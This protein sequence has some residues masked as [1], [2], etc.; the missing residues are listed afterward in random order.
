MLRITLGV[1]CL[2]LSSACAGGGGAPA[3]TTAIAPQGVVA[4]KQDCQ[5]VDS[6]FALGALV[7]RECGVERQAKA[8]GRQP[9]MDFNPR[10]PIKQCYNVVIAV[11][12]DERGSTVPATARI[13]RTNDTE[14]AQAFLNTVPEWRFTPAQKDGMPVKQVVELGQSAMTRQARSDRPMNPPPP[15]R[16]PNC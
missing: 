9:R 6:S 8:R 4:V 12:V 1:A 10:P 13:I 2:V 3:A 11:V 5:A 16:L 14:F 15:T 7:F